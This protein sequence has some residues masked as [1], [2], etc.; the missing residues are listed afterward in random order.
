M[1]IGE[2]ENF[3]LKL[4]FNCAFVLRTEYLEVDLTRQ[5]LTED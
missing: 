3:R 4:N 2:C 1:L 5:T